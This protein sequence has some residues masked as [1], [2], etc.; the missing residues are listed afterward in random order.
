ML[1]APD[2]ME[3]LAKYTTHTPKGTILVVK[4]DTPQEVIGTVENLNDF[5]LE[6]YGKE[7][8]KIGDF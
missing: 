5:Y 2:T 6:N 4:E 3:M 1:L 8:I 7:F